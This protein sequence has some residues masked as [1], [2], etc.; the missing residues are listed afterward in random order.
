MDDSFAN[1]L[2]KITSKRKLEHSEG[3]STKR[4]KTTDEKSAIVEEVVPIATTVP[5]AT[6]AAEIVE[7]VLKL[8]NGADFNVPVRRDGY[9]NVTKICQAAGKRLQNYKDR[10]DSK[11]FLDRFV[12]LTGIQANA[13][14][15]VL[16]G[17]NLANVEQGTFAHPD[18]AIHIAQ[19]CSAD[20][21]IQVSRWVRQLMTTGHVELGNEMNAKELDDVWRRLTTEQDHCRELELQ[22]ATIQDAQRLAKETQEAQKELMAVK[23]REDLELTIEALVSDTKPIIDSY[24]DGDNV[25]YLARIEGT[26][27]KYG[28]TK[29]THQRF[30]T[31]KR[32]GAY[33]GFDIVKVIGCANSVASEGKLR[34][35]VKKKNLGCNFTVRCGKQREIIEMKTKETL[36]RFVGAMQKSCNS[37]LEDSTN[38]MELKRL[39]TELETKRL[40]TELETKRLEMELE[41]KRL[42]YDTRHMELDWQFHIKTKEAA[43]RL[44]RELKTLLLLREGKLTFEQF[45]QLRG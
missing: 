40:E 45:L 14:F 13:I 8:S 22:L 17:G 38:I 37:I 10:V 20:F 5:I 15:K 29:N 6:N 43:I 33:E 34:D 25:I 23:A 3:F 32:Q 41:T 26:K 42:E 1:F 19:W 44:E 36:L 21:S 24:K 18:I 4:Q 7:F 27:F 9:V 39:E 11:H 28:Q 30:E 35:Y 12:A 2:Q 16:Q 31:H